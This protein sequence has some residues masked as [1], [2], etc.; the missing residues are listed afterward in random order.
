MLPNVLTGGASDGSKWYDHAGPDIEILDWY[1][2]TLATVDK[3]T[4][5]AAASAVESAKS[6]VTLLM[7][8]HSELLGMDKVKELEPENLDTE[9]KEAS[10]LMLRA[11]VTR[12]E[13]LLCSG[14]FPHEGKQ[15]LS[16]PQVDGGIVNRGSV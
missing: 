13:H 14:L 16:L 1:Q 7:S 12:Y 2:R 8:N 5:E 6:E 9:C 3:P 15:T 4:L 10:K 11:M